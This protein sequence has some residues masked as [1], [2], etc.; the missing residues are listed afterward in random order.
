MVYTIQIFVQC[1]PAARNAELIK[2]MIINSLDADS[3]VHILVLHFDEFADLHQYLVH[4]VLDP[5][6]GSHHVVGSLQYYLLALR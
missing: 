6:L 1:E 3:L 4:A 5:F 2:F